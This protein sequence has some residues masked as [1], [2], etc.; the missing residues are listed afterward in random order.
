MLT[1]LTQAVLPTETGADAENAHAA[2]E[3]ADVSHVD[4]A[5]RM[6]QVRLLPRMIQAQTQDHLL[7]KM[8]RSLFKIQSNMGLINTLVTKNYF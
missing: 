2:D 4:V 3:A 8:H 6:L 5:V 7:D 1:S